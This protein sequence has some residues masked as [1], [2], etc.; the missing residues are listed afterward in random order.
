ML[1]PQKDLTSEENKGV[2]EFLGWRELLQAVRFIHTLNELNF[3][4]STS[5]SVL[6]SR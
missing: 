6:R 1:T 4:G 2:P 3:N 5:I